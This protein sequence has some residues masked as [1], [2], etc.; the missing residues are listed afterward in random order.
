MA[1]LSPSIRPDYGKGT[2][3]IEAEFIESA[4]LVALVRRLF[5]TPGY[6]PPVLPD[7][8]LEVHNLCR[9]SDVSFVEIERLVEGCPMLTAGVLR[10]AQSPH[11]AAQSPVRS[12]RDATSRLGLRTLSDIFLEVSM[13]ARV[14]R[15]KGFETW[16]EALRLHSL[17]AAQAAR[18]IGRQTCVYEDF[19]YLCGLLHDVGV[20]GILIALSE[21]MV[22]RELGPTLAQVSREEL[23]QL[24][25]AAHGEAGQ[26]IAISWK[27]PLDVALVL[28]H[29]DEPMVQGHPYPATCATCVAEAVAA[30]CGFPGLA[31]V[32]PNAVALAMRT[33]GLSAAALQSIQ[34]DVSKS[35]TARA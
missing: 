21:P 3:S 33:L 31:R 26:V 20:A 28:Q 11:Y 16:M 9:R 29:H 32:E 22:A 14:F 2:A 25:S 5:Q 1:H 4:D 24:I 19:A 35:M 10:I 30:A 7:V 15:A 6:K 34:Q 13:S 17:A 8:A 27:L 12:L 18:L 23:V